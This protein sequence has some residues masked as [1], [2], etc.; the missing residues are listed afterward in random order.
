MLNN[1]K[2]TTKK[3]QKKKTTYQL[4]GC[5]K[6]EEFLSAAKHGAKFKSNW[7]C[8]AAM[9]AIYCG[10]LALHDCYGKP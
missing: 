5:L 10:W 7:Q 8:C 9:H 1:E 2:K 3:K 6:L 4:H